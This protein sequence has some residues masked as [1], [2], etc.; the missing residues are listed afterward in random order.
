MARQEQL[1]QWTTCVSTNMPELPAPQARILAWWSFGIALTGSCGQLA[2]AT[3]LAL[4]LKVKVANVE[5]RLYEWCLEADNKAGTQRQS[6]DVVAGQQAL[7]R[8]IVRLWRGTQLALTI[9]ATSLGSRFVALVVCVVSAFR[10]PGS[11]SQRD[12]KEVGDPPGCVCCA[13]CVRP[14]RATGR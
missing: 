4:L 5:Q 13:R 3:F 8:W 7:L 14:S 1:S 9:D 6:V 11:S 2:V 10:W 12:R